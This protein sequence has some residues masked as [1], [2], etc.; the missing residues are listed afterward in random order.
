MVL[1]LYFLLCGVFEVLEL[2]RPIKQYV[3]S[4]MLIGSEPSIQGSKNSSLLSCRLTLQSLEQ[5]L[6]ASILFQGTHSPPRK[7]ADRVTSYDIELQEKYY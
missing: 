5:I 4:L 1:K 2:A 6:L 7:R 3:F